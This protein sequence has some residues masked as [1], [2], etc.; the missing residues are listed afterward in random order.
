MFRDKRLEVIPSYMIASKENVRVDEPAKWR[1]KQTTNKMTKSYH[2]VMQRL[3]AEDFA[4]S[5]MHLSDVPFNPDDREKMSG[6]VYELP[7]GYSHDFVEERLRLPEALF[8]TAYVLPGVMDAA[9]KV[10][11]IP[12][13]HVVNTSINMCDVDIRSVSCSPG[14]IEFQSL[15]GGVLVTGGTTLTNGFVERLNNDLLRRCP[16]NCKLRVA[17]APTTA[18]RR[19]GTWVG[20]SIMASL[21]SFQQMWI[22]RQ[23][24][25][26]SG[27]SVVEKK[28]P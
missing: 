5:V 2:D 9:A 11:A 15:Y 19:F 23:E 13:A 28:C 12:M 27:K 4:R 20:G 6:V 1:P 24:Y 17:A 3:V 16:S 26:E 10:A 21:G 7:N 22:S 14:L 25:D 18:E 8:D